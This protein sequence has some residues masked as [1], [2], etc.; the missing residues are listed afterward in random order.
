[1]NTLTM[2]EF[3]QQHRHD[4]LV[5]AAEYR[6]AAQTRRGRFGRRRVR[7]ARTDTRPAHTGRRAEAAT[8]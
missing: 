8:R 1:M 7:T 2:A 6:E 3:A 5:E 4:L